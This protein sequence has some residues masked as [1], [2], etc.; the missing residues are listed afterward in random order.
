MGAAL[1]DGNGP[2]GRDISVKL[3]LCEESKAPF[4]FL[5]PSFRPYALFLKP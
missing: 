3:N 5:P 4:F 1:F 2:K